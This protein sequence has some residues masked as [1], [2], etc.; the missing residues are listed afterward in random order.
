MDIKAEGEFTVID[1][2]FFWIYNMF[3]QQPWKSFL[4]HVC[5]HMRD[6]IRK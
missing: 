4:L 6:K 3:L 1:M 5:L 2:D